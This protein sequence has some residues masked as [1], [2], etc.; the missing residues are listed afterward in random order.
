M[1]FKELTLLKYASD[2]V[3]AH[4]DFHFSND[5]ANVTP[6]AAPFKL[7]T[8]VHRPKGSAPTVAWTALAADADVV[9][10]NEF[11]FLF[12]DHYGF[13]YDFTP[14]AIKAKLFNAVVI[15]RGP[16]M[17]KEFYIKAVHGTALATKYGVLKQL[18]AD[19]G[20]VVLDDVT[21]FK[22]TL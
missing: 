2:L 3:I 22:G 20:V 17:L 10:T 8:I 5:N 1:A 21:N 16:A 14:K 4:A 18:L 13:K 6:G 9:D 11:A 15:K 12:G 19:Q 7:G